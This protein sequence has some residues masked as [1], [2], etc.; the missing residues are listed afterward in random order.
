MCALVLLLL[1][2]CKILTWRLVSTVDD[3]SG[4]FAADPQ[5]TFQHPY[6]PT[7]IM[8]IPDKDCMRPDLVATSGD[9]L[10]IWQIKEDTVQLLKLLNNVRSDFNSLLSFLFIEN[11]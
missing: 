8:F 4:K 2:P 3:E 1:G 10:R 11:K 7:K 9:F 6:P 5:L